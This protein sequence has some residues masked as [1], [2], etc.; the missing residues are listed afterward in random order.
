MENSANIRDYENVLKQKLNQAG[1]VPVKTKKKK[2][3]DWPSITGKLGNFIFK[4]VGN[5]WIIQGKVTDK[6]A[7]EISDKIID[8]QV[9]DNNSYLITNQG[10]L[11]AFVAVLKKFKLV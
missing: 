3:S 8:I 1:I 11:N 5:Y 7:R 2:L 10:A 9:V 6:A 4:P